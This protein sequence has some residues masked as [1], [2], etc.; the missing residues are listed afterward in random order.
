MKEEVVVILFVFAVVLRILSIF[1]R[2][3]VDYL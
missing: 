3:K 2:F 1:L